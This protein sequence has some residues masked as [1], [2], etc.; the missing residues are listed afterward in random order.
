MTFHLPP[1]VRLAETLARDIEQAV[2]KFH[3]A[4]RYT[5]GAD[6]RADMWAVLTTANRAARKPSERA[7]LLT[8]L[9]DQVDDLKQRLRLGQSLRQFN[10][11]GQFEALMRS[12][13]NLGQQIGGW[14]RQHH[15]KGQDG[16]SHAA[17]QR[18]MTLSTRDTS[19]VEVNQ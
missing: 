8:R 14:H 16:R 10:S 15:P 2:S 5:F 9:V 1:A 18:A 4:H 19:M 13:I 3:R 17:G 12:A 7:A 11:F 6:L